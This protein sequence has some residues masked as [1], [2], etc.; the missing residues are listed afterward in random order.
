[1]FLPVLEKEAAASFETDII[2]SIKNY[3]RQGIACL[4]KLNHVNSSLPSLTQIAFVT[5]LPNILWTL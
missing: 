2:I 5:I 1:M 4:E 3:W